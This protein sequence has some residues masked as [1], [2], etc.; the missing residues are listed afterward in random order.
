MRTKDLR[1]CASSQ[2]GPR[3]LRCH[4]CWLRS[5]R[6]AITRFVKG[7]GVASFIGVIWLVGT[8]MQRIEEVRERVEGDDHFVAG[9]KFTATR[10]SSE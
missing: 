7:L 8:S 6:D 2:A 4:D 5:G 1:A 10:C 9:G 3:V